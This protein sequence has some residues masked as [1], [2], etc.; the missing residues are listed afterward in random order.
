MPSITVE[1]TRAALRTFDEH[2]HLMALI[3]PCCIQDG[4][5][6]SGLIANSSLGVM[7]DILRETRSCIEHNGAE[8]FLV[9][10][11]LL[12]AEG[13]Y[14]VLACHIFSKLH[15][16][17]TYTVHIYIR[18]CT[19]SSSLVHIHIYT[20]YYICMHAYFRCS[21]NTYSLQSF[22]YVFS[23]MVTNRNLYNTV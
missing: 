17:R 1:D 12:Q 2:L 9:F 5:K 16:A 23:K 11:N 14:V 4:L 6:T 7:D 13:R 21:C 15:R 22:S 3:E 19:T 20:Y 10:I 18:I 8:K